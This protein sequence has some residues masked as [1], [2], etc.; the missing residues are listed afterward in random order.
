M[1]SKKSTPEEE[2]FARIEQENKTALRQKLE[3]EAADQEAMELRK[4]HYNRCGRCGH[5][6]NPQLFKGIEIDI[7]PSCNAVLLDPGELEQLVG[8]DKSGV[9]GSITELFNFSRPKKS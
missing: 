6:M 8:A 3:A 7:C 2:Y 9:M 5:E 4:L 1:S